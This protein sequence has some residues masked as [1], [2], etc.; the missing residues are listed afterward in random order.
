MTLGSAFPP[1]IW[2]PLP[3]PA[4]AHADSP[5]SGQIG[6]EHT[7]WLLAEGPGQWWG[8][9][10]QQARLGAACPVSELG[11]RLICGSLP[12]TCARSHATWPSGPA[13]T[14][15][16][17]QEAQHLTFSSQHHFPFGCVLVRPAM[18]EPCSKACHCF[19]ESHRNQDLLSHRH[20]PGASAGWQGRVEAVAPMPHVGPERF[21]R[22]LSAPVGLGF[23]SS[24]QVPN[25][26]EGL[27]ASLGLALPEP[28]PRGRRRP[29][30][31]AQ[32]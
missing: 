24:G 17:P 32:R 21:R 15:P 26:P 20:P 10:S 22:A 25:W 9:A 29:P 18:R 14:C 23:C 4:S 5:G 3:L 30:R 2:A 27:A 31:N 8:H 28:S 11:P 12:L 16:E 19:Q 1:A 6:L 13:A 7:E